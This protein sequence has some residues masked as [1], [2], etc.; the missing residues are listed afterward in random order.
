MTTIKFLAVAMFLASC[1]LFNKSEQSNDELV[2]L[3]NDV[4]K[5]QEGVEID[6][7]PIPVVKK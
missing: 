6:V 4:L 2:Q 7:K 1:T 3:T 5:K